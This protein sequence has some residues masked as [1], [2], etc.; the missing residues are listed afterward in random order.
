M[1]QEKM[2]STTA[3]CSVP[4]DDELGD[5]C[6]FGISDRLPVVVRKPEP[7]KARG[8]PD[9]RVIFEALTVTFSLD[10]DSYV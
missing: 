8:W 6:S 5:G 1:L 3:S 9:G 10:E 2:M 7:K 4:D